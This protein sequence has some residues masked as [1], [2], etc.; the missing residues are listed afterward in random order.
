MLSIERTR[1]MLTTTPFT[2]LAARMT[3]RVVSPSD[4][5]WDATR[6]VFNLAM[7]LSPAA[8]VLPSDATDVVVAVEYARANGLR[9]APQATGHNADALGSLEDV[10]LVDVRELQDV[11]IDPVAK[12]V[13][14]GAGVKWERVVPQL[15]EFGLAALHGSSPDVGIAG[16]SL[17]GGMGWLARKYGLQT[18]SVTALELVT[19]DG[20]AARVDAENEPELFWALRGGN[21]NFGLVTAIE[22]AVYPVAN[23][24]AGAMFFPF[25]R[26]GEVLD[27]WTELLPTLPDEMMTW[28]KLLQFPD[29]PD[30]PEPVRGGSFT[31]IFGAFLG[32]ESGGRGLLAPVREL[33]PAVDTFAVVPPAALGDL[34]M[35]PPDPL[36]FVTTTALLRDLPTAGVDDLVAAAGPGSGSP[37]AMVELRHMGGALAR[38]SPGAGARAT[39]PGSVAMLSIGVAEDEA[40]AAT[41]VTY[42]D[43]VDRAV[44]P[45]RTGD[46]PNLVMKP[47]DA[48][49]FFDPDTW[50]RLRHLKALYDPSDLFKGNHHIPP[51]RN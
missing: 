29:T 39:L 8:M 26:A 15:S 5:E 46:Y 6:Q 28:V 3:G 33:G 12:R 10:L 51:A 43:A 48:S 49:G 21:G 32:S 9:I 40:S 38:R 25:E 14:V 20:R 50:A 23:L 17:G 37:L 24:Y 41:A 35:D 34:A 22:F 7:D 44:L 47:S 36:P 2:E 45:Y 19:A 27:A 13:R 4:P 11:S 30:V 18:N 16:Y 31:I 1:E 42:L